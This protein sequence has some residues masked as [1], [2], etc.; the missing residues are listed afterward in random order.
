MH[1][2]LI[3]V[4]SF[5][6]LLG[7]MV[8]VHEFGHFAVAKLFGVRVEAF[9]VGMG[10]RLFGF[11]HG[12]TDYR[13]C[14]FPVGG[15]V[16]M[17]GENPGDEVNDVKG[18]I[19]P[20]AFTSHPRWQRMLIGLA[21]PVS[22]FILAFVLMLGYYWF[23]NEVPPYFDK[24]VTLDLVLPGTEAAKAGL[25]TGDQIVSF[26]STDNPS[27][28]QLILLAAPNLNHSVEMTVDR[29]GKR[30]ETHIFLAGGAKPEEF[31]LEKLGLIPQAQSGF[32]S[33]DRAEAGSP[34]AE[35]GLLRGDK[36]VAFDGLPLHFTN[37]LLPY[38][39]ARAGKPLVLT[40]VRKGQTLN[41]TAHPRELGV[42]ELGG[43]WRLGFAAVPPPEHAK[44]LD[45]VQAIGRSAAYS[46]DN[47]LL[48]VRVLGKVLSNQMSVKTL[49]GPVG[50][51]QMA[52]DAA[53]SQG[54]FPKFGLAAAISI[55]LGILNLLPIPILDGGLILLLLIESIRRKDLS[56]N[57][58]ERIYQTAFV[59]LML[60]FAFII[61]NDVSKLPLFAK[62]KL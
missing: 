38:L 21:G 7:V 9:S 53:Q 52:G 5:I 15:Y 8:V 35:A 6:V 24:S 39:Q 25:E 2:F 17:T 18:D 57:V 56:T 12:E 42:A 41:L 22:N 14:A 30:I 54:Y 16:K 45:F 48:I 55:N 50:M 27:Y 62:L 10:P 58:K 49:S 13:I 44:P 20:G 31:S 4:I 59:M 47:S 29:S 19:D 36:I 43:V 61:F 46:R 23:L 51:A 28:E 11:K 1:D 37:S 40:V 3:A 26:D 34:A 32:V 60:L 33:V